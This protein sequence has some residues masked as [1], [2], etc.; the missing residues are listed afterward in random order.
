MDGTYELF[1]HYFAVPKHRTAAG[2]EVGAL[3]GVLGS[4]LGMLEGGVTHVGVATDHVIESFRNQL[5]PGYK[6]SAG[7]EA[8]LLEQFWPLE[9]A[10][11]AMGVMVWAMTELEADDALASAAAVASRD[12]RV[13]QVLICT[14]DKD[15]T[16]VVS[17]KRIVQFDRRKRELRDETGVVE[18]FGVSPRSIPDYLA[19]VGDSSDGF[20]GLP[21]W[22]PKSASTLLARYGHLEHIPDHAPAWDVSLRG[23]D[24]L[25][26]TLAGSRDTALLFRDLATLRIDTSLLT[27]V[28]ELRWRGPRETFEALC[29]DLEEPELAARAAAITPQT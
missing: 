2:A 18:K 22:G 20:P 3:R 6:S 17:H 16:Q 28:D 5:W 8:D 12:E 11:E 27:D 7:I 24:R 21:G 10:L 9:E 26:A 23:A 29:R 4:V 19:L 25:A 15:V 1:R 13:E 14:P